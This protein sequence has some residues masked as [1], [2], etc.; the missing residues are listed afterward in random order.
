MPPKAR[1]PLNED[2]L[3]ADPLAFENMA[4]VHT[5]SCDDLEQFITGLQTM[6]ST[7]LEHEGPIDEASEHQTSPEV[8][9]QPFLPSPESSDSDKQAPARPRRPRRN[10]VLSDSD[11]ELDDALTSASR[12]R[13]QATKQTQAV[14][15]A[16][17]GP[18]E[19][20]SQAWD[21]EKWSAVHVVSFVF[22]R[23]VK[24]NMTLPIVFFG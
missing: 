22:Q 4:V 10:V 12:E 1:I 2:S 6:S 9:D 23:R 5:T 19:S 17:R 20:G 15:E 3:F 24:P 14:G 8:Q 18:Q 7:H 13:S 11:F 21:W 16:S